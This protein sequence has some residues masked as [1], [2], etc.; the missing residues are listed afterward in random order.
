[1]SGYI[2]ASFLRPEVGRALRFQAAAS[3]AVALN[4]L[5]NFSTSTAKCAVSGAEDKPNCIAVNTEAITAADVAAGTKFPF[6]TG[7]EVEAVADV[8][9]NAGDWLAA[10]PAGTVT[11]V[12]LSDDAFLSAQAGTAF[13]NQPAND[14]LEI[15][16]S[17]TSDSGQTLRVWGT[18]QGTTTLVTEDITTNG[19]SVVSTSKT[20]WGYILGVEIAN[21]SKAA[22]GTITVRE[23]SGNSAVTTITAGNKRSGAVKTA[24]GDALR[25][26]SSLQSLVASG[27]ST[28]LVGIVGTDQDGSAASEVVTLAGTTAVKTVNK[29]QTITYVLVGDVESS[30]TVTVT[31]TPLVDVDDLLIG[32]AVDSFD[33]GETGTILFA[34]SARLFGKSSDVSGVGVVKTASVTLTASQVNALSATQQTLVAAPGPNKALIFMGAELKYD[35]GSSAFGGVDSGDDFGIKYT[36]DAGVQVAAVET[37]GFIDQTNDERRWVNPTSTAAVEFV[38]NAPLVLDGLGDATSSGTGSTVTIVTHYKVIDII[39]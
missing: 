11:P 38:A 6:S 16:S 9:I 27:S 29:Y 31:S 4:R 14:G 36:S 37:T 2:R 8:N 19:T 7:G 35:Y 12:L 39:A 10:G 33:A 1:M 26:F 18:T 24:Q 23:A 25:G 28:K 34:P 32:V 15:L 30:R 13:G 20:D 5:C 21:G 3:A 22:V 17:S